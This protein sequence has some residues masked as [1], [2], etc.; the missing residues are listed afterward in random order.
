[1]CGIA[2]FTT[3]FG[4]SGAARREEFGS[5]L[6]RMTAALRHRGPDAAS[7]VLLDGAALG[8]TRLAIL[9]LSGGAQPMRD[10]ATGVTLVFNGEIFNYLE[11]RE[12]LA[13]YPF[14]TRS[15]TEVVLAAFLRWGDGCLERFNGQFA[16]AIWDPRARALWLARDRVGILPLHYAATPGGIAFGSE[17]KALLAGGFG[18]PRLDARGVKQA[19]QLWSPVAPRTCIEGVCALPP[20]TVARFSEGRLEL[21][22][23]WAL[24]L[25]QPP[26]PFSEDEAVERVGALL[27]DAVRLR[28]RADV[29]VA[30]YLSGGID[31]SVICAIA[32]RQLG[33]TLSTFSV[34]FEDRAYDERPFQEEVA[35]A[36]R[37]RHHVVVA[38]S[39]AVGELLPRVVGHAEQVLV[40]T[41][42]APLLTLSRDVR[43]SGGKVVLTGEGSDEIFLGYDLYAETKVRQFWARQP[44]SRSRPTLFRRLYPY[45]A[46]SAQGDAMLRQV[47][48]AGLGEPS[49]PGFSHLCRWNA[50]ARVLR[51]LSPEFAAGVAAEDPPASAVASWGEEV[52]GWRPLARAQVLEMQT[53]LAGNLLAA[54]GDRMLMANS[55]EGRFP[56]LDHRLIELAARLPERLKLRGLSGKWV[57]R[58]YARGLVPD[59]VLDRPKFPYRSPPV[60]A[61]VG[62]SAPPWARELLGPRALRD[63]GVF[64]PDKVGR[65]IAKLAAPRPP[66]EVDAMGM[67]AVATGQLLAQSLAPHLDAR[68]LDAVRMEVA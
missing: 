20:A 53:L 5:R 52:R 14:L 32:Q 66:S 12:E 22:R 63:T 29:P 35:T 40:R 21:R 2:G 47:F 61:L 62:A 11:L 3:P 10:P 57:L 8:H 67:T 43:E 6:R 56:F 59:V 50:S 1:M 49:A 65:L 64:D 7:A 39:E 4:L 25:G 58:R 55:V 13:G 24:D 9:D 42:P 54:Q 51:L 27:E 41:A 28:L 17:A 15:D 34:G 18:A 37:T 16:C 36:L 60:R 33:G 46:L 45:L 19:I 30:A 38:T 26:E 68:D 48:G 31:S 23:W 44:G